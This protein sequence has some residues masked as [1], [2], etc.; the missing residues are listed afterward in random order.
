[1][2]EILKLTPFPVLLE[3]G[4]KGGETEIGKD[5]CLV[6]IDDAFGKTILSG[7]AHEVGHTLTLLDHAPPPVE[8]LMTTDRPWNHNYLDKKRFKDTD[9]TDIK[10][11]RNYYVPLNQ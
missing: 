4:S 2:S 8:W 5:G 10:G 1:M 7:T 6:S 3:M 11:T 9:E